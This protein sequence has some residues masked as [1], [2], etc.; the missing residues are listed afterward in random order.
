MEFTLAMDAT[1][2]SRPG[3]VVA[4]ANSSLPELGR[5]GQRAPGRKGTCRHPQV[6]SQRESAWIARMDA[7]DRRTTG[8]AST[9]R[10]RGRPPVRSP[11]F[12][13]ENTINES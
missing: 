4:V 3:V 9:L 1:D 13:D 2:R 5:S 6:R 10:N 11:E 12:P 8:L 7:T